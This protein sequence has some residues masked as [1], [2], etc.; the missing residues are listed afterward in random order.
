MI[1]RSSAGVTLFWQG[2]AKPITAEI[3]SGNFFQVLGVRPALGRLF[4]PAD[5]G[6]PG[7]SPVVVLDHAYWTSGFGASPGVL[8]QK[9][10]ING[11]PMTVI[12]VADASFHGV[13]S[14]DMRELYVP[15]AMQKAVR[16]TWDVLEDQTV[17]W[18]TVFARLKPGLSVQQ[19]QA[20]TNLAYRDVL[21]TELPRESHMDAKETEKFLN[22]KLQLRPAAQG[23]NALRQHWEK[24]LAALMAMV[25]L[26]LLIACANIAGLMLRSEERRV[27]K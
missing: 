18:L 26:V 16:P 2:S 24:P 14:G 19:A 8:N 1:A 3:V 13:L 6:A 27:G 5:D 10:L 21:Q 20:A 17:R 22:H 12:G 15:I 25:G 11:H 4:T 9:V 7:A 23:I